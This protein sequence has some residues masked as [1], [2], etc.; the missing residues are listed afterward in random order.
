[1][2]D[3]RKNCSSTPEENQTEILRITQN[4]L[5]LNRLKRSPKTNQTPKSDFTDFRAETDFKTPTR[6]PKVGFRSFVTEE[7]PNNDSELQHE[8]IWDPTSPATPVRTGRGRRRTAV[9]KSMDI[10]DIVNRIAPKNKKLEEAESSLLQWIGDTAVPCTPEIREPRTKP[11]P[12]RQNPVADLLKLAKQ[13]DFNMIQ[14][15]EAHLQPNPQSSAEAMHE[16]HDLFFNENDPPASPQTHSEA[17]RPPLGLEDTRMNGNDPLGDLGPIQELDDDLD[18]LFEGSTQEVSGGLSQGFS[19]RS[20]DAAKVSPKRGVNLAARASANSVNVCGVT[21]TG[22]ASESSAVRVCVAAPTLSTIKQLRVAD[23]FDDDWNND[24][25]DDSLVMEM[26][27]NPELFSAPQCSSTQKQTNKNSGSANTVYRRNGD[28][29]AKSGEVQRLNQRLESFQCGQHWNKATGNENARQSGFHAKKG[30]EMQV[31]SSSKVPSMVPG[32]H[33]VSKTNYQPKKTMEIQRPLAT[34]SANST[35]KVQSQTTTS[36]VSRSDPSRSV[37]SATIATTPNFRINKVTE[38]KESHPTVE[39]D[40]LGDLAAEDLDSIFASDDIWDDGA[41]D[42]DLFCEACGKVEESMAEP[43]PPPKA[44]VSKSAPQSSRVQSGQNTMGKY[45]SV[46]VRPSPSNTQVYDRSST[47]NRAPLNTEVLPGAHNNNASALDKST[48][49]S[50]ERKY[51]FSHVK[52]TT[53]TGSAAY[54]AARQ[55]SE[56]TTPTTV[57]S[58]QRIQENHQFKKPYSTF[59]AAPAV[60]KDVSKAVVT[61]CSDAEIERKKQ[62][63][64]ERR[65]LRMLA[66]Q[67]LQAPV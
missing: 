29:K 62:Q 20:Q 40:V 52:S 18:L 15:E 47:G 42:D 44:S 30:P 67:N 53:G 19:A 4:K 39:D 49:K 11:K 56:S 37:P 46:F 9:F 13:F 5:K 34:T 25:L 17:K 31:F 27:Q 26:T 3:G 41:D 66:N 8:I 36:L 57:Q 7:S 6:V 10:S 35:W 24:L 61:R 63:A 28:K 16:D 12:T 55:V 65:R 2:N 58:Y 23:D 64:M 51:K 50:S 60:S 21:R 45:E 38:E 48:M 14:Q 59:N 43:E 54:N 1:M 32:S 22:G 33:S